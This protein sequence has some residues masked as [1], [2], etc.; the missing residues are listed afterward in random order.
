MASQVNRIYLQNLESTQISLI[1]S[2]SCEITRAISSETTLQEYVDNQL[3]S[4]STAIASVNTSLE[5]LMN[6]TAPSTENSISNT[7]QTDVF[8]TALTSEIETR[9][10]EDE[11]LSQEI[12]NR[13]AVLSSFLSTEISNRILGEESLQNYVDFKVNNLTTISPSVS[14]AN[15]DNSLIE[16]I[17]SSLTAETSDRI[18]CDTSLKQYIDSNI[19]NILGG[20]PQLLDSLNELASAIKN[21]SNISVTLINYVNSQISNEILNKVSESNMLQSSI[22]SDVDSC[23]SKTT[24]LSTNLGSEISAR[25]S[26]DTFLLTNL[27]NE[28]SNRI[29]GYSTLSTNLS[30]EISKR[31][32][33]N[34][35][36]STDLKSEIDNTISRDAS[37][38]TNIRS[39]ISNRIFCNESLKTYIDSNI[40]NILGGSPQFLDSLHELASAIK[41]DPN[42][43]STTMNHI[44]S[45]ISTTEISLSTAI[46]TEITNRINGNTSLASTLNNVGTYLSATYPTVPTVELSPNIYSECGKLSLPANTKWMLNI[47][48]NVLVNNNN[49]LPL[50]LQAGYSQT[51]SAPSDKNLVIQQ[52]IGSGTFTVSRSYIINVGSSDSTYYLVISKLSSPVNVLVNMSGCLMEAIRIS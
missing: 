19:K 27:N 20:S 47:N 8:Q 13:N 7:F 36:L 34:T 9:V 12:N 32:T 18:F 50:V 3:K 16:N 4:Q 10:S 30:N 2:L 51:I 6:S 42:F 40:T 33:E 28:I 37:L 29:S 31:I 48:A 49:N 11:R 39:E 5:R 25:I 45:K 35:S 38:S 24:S 14:S 22:V 23:V 41:S 1:K 15:I 26:G 46:E 21:E 17:S 43:L 52:V 44:N